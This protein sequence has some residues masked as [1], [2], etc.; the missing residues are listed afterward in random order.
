MVRQSAHQTSALEQFS[1][2]IIIMRLIRADIASFL[3]PLVFLV[4]AQNLVWA[5]VPEYDLKAVYLERFTRF[6]EW[7]AESDITDSTK[8]FTIGVIGKNPLGSIIEQIFASRKIR[9]KKIAV[10][11]IS[12][13]HEIDKCHLLFISEDTRRKV[14]DIVAYTKDKP[15]LTVSDTKGYAENGVLINFYIEEGRLRFEINQSAVKQSR[16][17]VSYML[18]QHARI[19][20]LSQEHK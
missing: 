18:M 11:Y 2:Q 1:L 20:N 6:V 12:K 16:L 13:M 3:T 17:K 14:S 15:I 5:Q 4:L 10:R 9:N 7:P 19:L 8:P